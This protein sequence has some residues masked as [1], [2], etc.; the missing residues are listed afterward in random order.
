MEQ[1]RNNIFLFSNNFFLLKERVTQMVKTSYESQM[2]NR[3]PWIPV[4][5][6][7]RLGFQLL[8]YD[9]FKLRDLSNVNC[10]YLIINFKQSVLFFSPVFFS[11]PSKSSPLL[12]P[13]S[14]CFVNKALA[15]YFSLSKQISSF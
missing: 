8:K 13:C 3:A 6:S 1:L 5:C 15:F 12:T 10:R 2:A 9:V 14:A 7:E 11:L 4:G